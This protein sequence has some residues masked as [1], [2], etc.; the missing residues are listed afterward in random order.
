MKRLFVLL[1]GLLP[2]LIALGM[3]RYGADALKPRAESAEPVTFTV[4]RGATLKAIARDLE[5]AALVRNAFAVEWL[6]RWQKLQLRAGEYELS[7]DLPPLEIL[8]RIASGQSKTYPVVLPEGIR[9]EEIATRLADQKLVEPE[10]FLALM[11]DPEFVRST[12]L[13]ADSLE[14][15]LY[16]ETYRI[17]RG[18]PEAEVARILVDQFLEVWKPL[19]EKAHGKGMTMHE[20]VTLAS[21]V[22]KETGAPAERP[23]IAGVFHNR[24]KRGMRLASDPTVIYGIPNFDG[25]LRR[26]DLEN[27]DNPYNTY[28]IPGLPPGPIA[29]PGGDALR[30]VVEPAETE[31][32]FFVSR[33]DGT[34]K[35]SKSYA[36]HERAVDEFQRRRRRR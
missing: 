31:Y 25:N 2:V 9:I 14:G 18:L 26:R 35:F 16:P 17:P 13:E 29:N 36:E 3:A 27:G 23:L 33:N 6:A 4:A 12:G 10:S 30:A 28:K 15:Y 24:L 1:V 20:V 22:E 19:E 8:Q 7:A 5:A 11:R 21:I 34:H 32:L